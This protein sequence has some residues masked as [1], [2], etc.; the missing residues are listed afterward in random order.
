MTF[1]SF[2]H[3]KSVYEI[4][5]VEFDREGFQPL[6]TFNSLLSFNS[7]LHKQLNDSFVDPNNRFVPTVSDPII[8]SFIN[9]YNEFI[10]GDIMLVYM[11]N[12]DV[13]YFKIDDSDSKQE[14]RNLEKGKRIN[15]NLVPEKSRIELASKVFENLIISQSANKQ[16][17][18][19][20]TNVEGDCNNQFRA[21][22]SGKST[23][24]WWLPID[25]QVTINWGDGTPTQTVSVSGNFE[26]DHIYSTTGVF[27]IE[28]SMTQ[29]GPPSGPGDP[30]IIAPNS[31][32]EFEVGSNCTDTE[33]ESWPWAEEGNVAMSYGPSSY[34]TSFRHYTAAEIF[35]FEFRDGAW[36]RDNA[37]SL[38]VF[39]DVTYRNSNCQV[40][41]DEDEPQN[42]NSCD[43][44]RARVN[45]RKRN[46]Y[47]RIGEGEIMGT[48]RLVNNNITINRDLTLSACQ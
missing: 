34:T 25:S 18:Q 14:I 7:E 29:F 27:N 46:R 24:Y 8:R 31:I 19:T 15:R 1:S 37:T 38:E 3:F 43:D 20:L 33:I 41:G 44:K 47:H 45:T 35:S 4:L 36:R 39:V 6:E 21:I 48:F 16:M 13:I 11:D 17:P 40:S 10:I 32:F 28:A 42:C 30:I 23:K 9:D 5:N 12:R 26:I 22:L 2:D